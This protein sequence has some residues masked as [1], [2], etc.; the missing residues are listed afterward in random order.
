VSLRVTALA[1]VVVV[2]IAA[3][4]VI[5]GVTTRISTMRESVL[6][7]QRGTSA[8]K[9]RTDLLPRLP[10]E[11]ETFNRRFLIALVV[12]AAVTL[13]LALLLT[14]RLVLAPIAAL[15]SAVRSVERGSLSERVDIDRNDEI[16]DLARSFNDLVARLEDSEARRKALIA[17]IAHELR[18]PLTN[19]RG[20]IESLQDGIVAAS[21]EELQALHND[22]L[23]LQRLITDLHEIS[24]ADAGAL[25]LHLIE[26]HVHDE[27]Q[28]AVAGPRVDLE[29]DSELPRV[30]CDPA[31]FRQIAQ[32]I[33]AN[34]LRYA[35]PGTRVIVRA[36]SEQ[37]GVRIEIED[38]GPGFP[39]S[40]AESIFERFYRTD[41]SRSRATGGSGLGLAIAKKLVEA[42]RGQIGAFVNQRGGA[43]IWLTLPAATS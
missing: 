24:I 31:R 38:S 19:I 13:T 14:N 36:K 2:L 6:I 41:D 16:G 26:I 10:E 27:L 32:N 35:P 21:P 3:F 20:S 17:D 8:P 11:I 37:G 1:V 7:V 25:S 34:A 42:H 4:A 12:I 28:T 15:T 40:E 29:L 5:G 43:T 39:P 30:R 23:L 33:L 9:I 22:A 18:T